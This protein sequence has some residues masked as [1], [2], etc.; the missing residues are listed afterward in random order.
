MA[1]KRDEEI[2][3][4]FKA[5]QSGWA[6][7]LRA[8][9]HAPPDAGY[10]ARM[11]ALCRAAHA[12]ALICWEAHEAGYKW[13]RHRAAGGEP[14]YELR[15]ESGRRGPEIAWL[16]FDVAVEALN[17]ATRGTDLHRV[18]S[19][20][21]EMAVAAGALAEEIELQD[22]ASGLLPPKRLM[23]G[24]ASAPARSRKSA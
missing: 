19:A 21:E 3:V 20:Y 10:S 23:S 6:D 7:A 2:Q 18:G 24:R 8:H 14:P 22:R 4:A 12:E 17:R 9:R 11:L 1:D 13:P 15:P 5:A 16:R